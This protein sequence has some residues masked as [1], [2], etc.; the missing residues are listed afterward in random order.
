MKEHFTQ[1]FYNQVDGLI[2]RSIERQVKRLVEDVSREKPDSL[3]VIRAERKIKIRGKQL[4]KRYYG[5]MSW[6][7]DAIL[8]AFV[9]RLLG[10]A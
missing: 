3:S 7:P 9:N 1:K 5:S 10:R 2:G 6:L 4:F 8:R